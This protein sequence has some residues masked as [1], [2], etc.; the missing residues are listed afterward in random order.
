M[1]S[2]GGNDTTV[3][4]ST[5]SKYF[6]FSLPLLSFHLFPLLLSISPPPLLVF[7]IFPSSNK[8]SNGG[9]VG[10]LGNSFYMYNSVVNANNAT[11]TGGNPGIKTKT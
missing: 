11:G 8:C 5:F 10:N 4:G 3:V 9:G 1:Y 6:I 7:Y 2:I